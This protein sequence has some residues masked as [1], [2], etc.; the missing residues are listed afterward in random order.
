LSDFSQQRRDADAL[1]I[2]GDLFEFWVGDDDDSASSGDVAAPLRDY[3]A[4]GRR[5]YLMHGNR[6]FLIGERFAD[7]GRRHAA[8]LTPACRA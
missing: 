8:C 7:P 6:D 5:L 1:Y 2:L 4:A 3:S